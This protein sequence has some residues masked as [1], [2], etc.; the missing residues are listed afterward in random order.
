MLNYRIL[1]HW[2]WKNY[3]VVGLQLGRQINPV[4]CVI[5][6]PVIVVLPDIDDVP[7]PLCVRLRQVKLPW[8]KRKI[9]NFL[10]K[11]KKNDL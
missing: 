11:K 10:K 6:D 1:R 2:E 9:L 4:F 7:V 3:R 8:W 5:L